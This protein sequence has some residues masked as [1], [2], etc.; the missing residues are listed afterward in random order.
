MLANVCIAKLHHAWSYGWNKLKRFSPIG[1]TYAS[2]VN[3]CSS[4]IVRNAPYGADWNKFFFNEREIFFVCWYD[5]LWR[6]GGCISSDTFGT[7]H[8]WG[9]MRQFNRF[10]GTKGWLY[11][12][13]RT[14]RFRTM[15]NIPLAGEAWEAART[16]WCS[17]SSEDDTEDT[18]ETEHP[19]RGWNVHHRTTHGASTSRQE[20]VGGFS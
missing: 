15:G 6:I 2:G 7:S 12:W 5:G 4:A 8:N 1:A 3:S 9:N 16:S 11:M 18:E 10:R 19:A 17:W 20:E 13:E 14:I